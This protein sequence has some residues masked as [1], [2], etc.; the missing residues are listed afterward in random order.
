MYIIAQPL[1]KYLGIVLDTGDTFG[2]G[3]CRFSDAATGRMSRSCRRA[4]ES[5]KKTLKRCATIYYTAWGLGV[6]DGHSEIQR[7]A[8][9]AAEESTPTS[10]MRL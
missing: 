8:E 9:E 4:I 7:N 6:S 2:A 3:I 10:Y 1:K 5:E